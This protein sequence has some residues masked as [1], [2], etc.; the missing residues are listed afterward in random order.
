MNLCTGFKQGIATDVHGTAPV[1]SR[2]RIATLSAEGF[3][4]A[5]AAAWVVGFHGTALCYA[6]GA[7]ALGGPRAQRPHLV[8]ASQ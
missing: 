1:Q 6:V 8:I 3:A 4:T 2:Y 5:R 7:D